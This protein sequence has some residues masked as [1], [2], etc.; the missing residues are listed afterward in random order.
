MMKQPKRKY[1]NIS[2]S[3]DRLVFEVLHALRGIKAGDIQEASITFA[4]EYKDRATVSASTISRWRKPLNKG[5]TRYP[6][7]VKLDAALSIVGKKLGIV[8]D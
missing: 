2:P 5:G 1:R 8:E 6:Q 3:R 4:T 7:A